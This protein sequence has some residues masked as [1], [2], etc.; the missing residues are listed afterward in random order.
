M[1]VRIPF[2][3]SVLE[4]IEGDG[5]WTFSAPL[6]AGGIVSA[7]IE[8]DGSAMSFSMSERSGEAGARISIAEGRGR[9]VDDGLDLSPET[10]G[11]AEVFVEALR[12]VHADVL[13]GE[14]HA[15]N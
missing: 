8:K 10:Y 7:E 15:L 9:I 14:V 1:Q 11:V 4:R 2:I 3:E 6:D 13:A 5:R 12:V